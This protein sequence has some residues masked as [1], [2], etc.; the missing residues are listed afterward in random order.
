MTPGTYNFAPHY[1]GD[2]FN[3]V[4]FDIERNGEPENL[5]GAVAT[6]SISHPNRRQKLVEVSSPSGVAI[7]GN[8]VSVNPLQLPRGSGLFPW[9]LTITYLT[10]AEKT[11][12]RGV[13]PIIEDQ[14]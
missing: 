13:L 8:K 3:G 4:Q 1:G 2:T 10:G 11:Y 14:A 5:D 9:D 6:F 7:D 12:I